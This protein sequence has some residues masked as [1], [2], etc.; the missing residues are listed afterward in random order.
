MEPYPIEMRTR[1]LADRDAGMKPRAVALKYRMSESWVWPLKQRRRE[2][3][4]ITARKAGST[5][6]QRMSST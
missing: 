1:D 4:E 6:S 5:P 2:N 3:G